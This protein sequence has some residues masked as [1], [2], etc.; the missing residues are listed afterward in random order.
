[1]FNFF[2]KQ[3]KQVDPVLQKMKQISNSEIYY[4]RYVN[5]VEA[6][7]Y[8]EEKRV[9]YYF[10]DEKWWGLHIS[11]GSIAT[12]MCLGGKSITHWACSM[13]KPN[14]SLTTGNS[15]ITFSVSP[16][17]D[18]KVMID[19]KNLDYSAVK[20]K[21]LLDKLCVDME[22]LA[23][24]QRELRDIEHAQIMKEAREAERKRLV[25]ETKARSFGDD[26]NA[27]YNLERDY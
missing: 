14:I 23:R 12:K 26:V 10:F 19:V 5:E 11:A 15:S 17:S 8:D 4:F 2:K 16:Y 9:L 3:E 22:V 20:I 7:K 24:Q 21:E 27:L 1:M 25:Q 6:F 13:S 18:N